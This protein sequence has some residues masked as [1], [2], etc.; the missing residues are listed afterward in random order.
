MALRR[1]TEHNAT[2][3]S[4]NLNFNVPLTVAAT[5]FKRVQSRLQ[6]AAVKAASEIV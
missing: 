5:L 1:E 6:V 3:L 4:Q 2:T